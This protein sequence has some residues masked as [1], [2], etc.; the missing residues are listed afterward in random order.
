MTTK[1]KAAKPKETPASTP[2]PKQSLYARAVMSER[3][4]KADWS[5][6][7]EDCIED[8]RQVQKEYPDS[9]ISRNF[10]RVNGKYSDSTWNQHFGT[11]AQFRRSA[12]L[13][14]SRSQQHLEKKIA[15]HAHLDVYREFYTSEVAPWVGKYERKHDNGRIKTLVIGSDFHDVESDEFVLSVFLDTVKRVQPD[16]IVLN[17]DVF[18]MYE[19]SRYDQDPREFRIKE[20]YDFVRERIFKPLREIAPDTQIDFIVGNHEQRMLKLLADRTPAMKVLIDLMGITFSQL[21]GL[22]EWK[23]NL[24]SKNDFAAYSSKEMHEE[25]KRNYRRYFDTVVVHHFGDEQY[26]LSSVG[27]H[28][29]KPKMTTMANE[30]VGPVWQ[31]TTGAICKIDASYHEQKVNAQNGFAIVHIDTYERSAVAENILFGKKFTVVAGKYY[32]RKEDGENE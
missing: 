21:L 18:D 13:E 25:V 26:A 28:T 2:A 1:K 4:K 31:I 7:K 10:Y 24:I 15:R 8:L 29:H 6:S 3:T 30:A 5:A 11:F 23:I 16:V 32:F 22:D 14:L 19:L 9:F 17:G 12:D 27:G 20:R